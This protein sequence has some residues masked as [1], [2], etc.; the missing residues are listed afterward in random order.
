MVFRNR[1]L[2]VILNPYIIGGLSSWC[3]PQNS[4]EVANFPLS[5]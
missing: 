2:S 3:T 1:F 5:R 4:D